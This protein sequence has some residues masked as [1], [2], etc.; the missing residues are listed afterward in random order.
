MVK[1]MTTWTKKWSNRY[2][3]DFRRCW[4]GYLLDDHS[5]FAG[6]TTQPCVHT[7]FWFV[8]WCFVW[9]R[10]PSFAGRGYFSKVLLIII[11]IRYEIDDDLPSFAY[12]KKNDTSHGWI[13]FR[14]L[15]SLVNKFSVRIRYT[16]Y[17]PHLTQ[18]R[19]VKRVQQI[20]GFHMTNW[21]LSC[22][23]AETH[24]CKKTWADSNRVV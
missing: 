21:M 4:K 16:W 24:R 19:G 1:L 6:I 5:D 2:I 13:I 17:R 9:T 23:S 3:G 11:C 8:L 7:P 10:F 18:L 15:Q 22:K 12:Q 14:S 20:E